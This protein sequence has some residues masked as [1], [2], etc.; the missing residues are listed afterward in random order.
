M[1]PV[2]NLVSDGQ[3]SIRIS[4]PIGS[5]WWDDTGTTSSQ[6]VAALDAIPRGKPVA[7]YVNSEGG[8]IKDGLEIYNAIKARAAD[9]TAHITGYALSIASV[10][11]LAASKVITPKG[12]VWM[13]HKPWTHQ[14]GNADDM[15]NAADMLDKH[16]RALVAIYAQET[17]QDPEK[18]RADLT[19]ETWMAGDEAVAYGLADEMT[20]EPVALAALEGSRFRRMPAAMGGDP[21]TRE[22]NKKGSNMDLNATNTAPVAGT[23]TP[24]PAAA[25]TPAGDTLDGA[26]LMAELHQIK[27]QLAKERK[28]RIERA[29][30]NA[31]ADGQ[32]VADQRDA[33]T[34][35]CLKDEGAL[36]MLASL[37]KRPSNA[38]E[39]LRPVISAGHACGRDHVMALKSPK[40]RV[41]CMVENWN[42]FRTQGRRFAPVAAN[43]GTDSATLLGTML[44]QQSVTV[45]Q[46]MLGPIQALSYEVSLDPMVPLK[47]TII[48][49]VTAGGTAQTNATNFEDTTNFVGT[50]TEKTVTP[51][52]YT[53]GGYLSVA[54]YNAGNKMAQ[55]A[56]IKAQEIGEKLLGVINALIVTGTFTT[57]VQTIASAAFSWS[58]LNTIW[59]SLAKARTKNAILASAYVAKLL[60]TTRESLNALEGAPTGWNRFDVNDYW[61]GATSGTQGFFCHPQA[62]GVVMGAPETPATA[63]R[64][65][66]SQSVLN[67]PGLGAAIQVN[68]WFNTATRS[69]WFTLDTVMGAAVVDAT[70]GRILKAS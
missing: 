24:P 63:N 38:A 7:L 42:E 45:L 27:D 49:V 40:E 46:T 23:A 31:I 67:I 44:E 69:D 62:I 34:A 52:R 60:P 50:V 22:N 66:L 14:D 16:E 55:W 8:S 10:I 26:K 65:G 58:D 53:S 15:R 48:R 21:H 68:N 9:V 29:V 51:S 36:A 32:I 43:T 37:P 17:G 57:D 35:Q 61:T 64:A 56:E 28:Q 47:P 33:W 11:P 4:G 70:A 30:D 2:F 1:K 39:P 59:G 25:N 13:L 20:D 6:F 5:S 41:S 3:T 18:I 54:E 12:S 19:A